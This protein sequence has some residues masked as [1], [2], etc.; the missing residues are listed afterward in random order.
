MSALLV[1]GNEK[2]LL[3]KEDQ[4]RRRRSQEIGTDGI[5]NREP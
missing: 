3:N 2:G 5:V 4:N 1:T